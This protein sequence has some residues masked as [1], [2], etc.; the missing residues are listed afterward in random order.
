M[1]VRSKSL[2][3]PADLEATRSG[4]AGPH[5]VEVLDGIVVSQLPRVERLLLRIL[6]P[7]GDLEDLVQTVFLE[8]CRAMPRFRGGCALST[9][10]GGI[11]VRV[12][13]RAMRPSP[14]W[15]RRGAMPAEEVRAPDPDLDRQVMASEQL[16]RVR[17]ALTGMSPEK[18]IAFLLWALE[19]LSV[20]EIAG[21]TGA[22]CS[23]TRSRIYQARSALKAQAATDPYLKELIAGDD[24]DEGADHGP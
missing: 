3:L 6:G 11:T 12:A 18:R 20:A 22:S 19:G 23:A 7:R 24:G 16:R 2:A 17:A 1:S 21:M 9:F 5:D 10:I 14:W 13:R 15:R 4:A 8:T